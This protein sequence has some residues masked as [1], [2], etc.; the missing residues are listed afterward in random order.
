MSN[1]EWIEPLV[2]VAVQVVGRILFPRGGGYGDEISWPW[3]VGVALAVLAA[4][5]S[6]TARS[7]DISGEADVVRDRRRRVFSF[8]LWFSWAGIVWSL[9]YFR[10]GGIV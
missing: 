2:V 5:A 6:Q 1:G 8:A 7:V 10:L 9:F 3:L 4:F